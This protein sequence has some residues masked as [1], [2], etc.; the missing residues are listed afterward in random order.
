MA[1]KKQS[2]NSSRSARGKKIL[3]VGLLMALLTGLGI[4]AYAKKPKRPSTPPMPPKEKPKPAPLPAPVTRPVQ[5]FPLRRGMKGGLVRQMQEGLL[6]ISPGSLPRFGA[7]GDFGGE[8]E[9][10]LVTLGFP[11]IVDK[12]IFD[13]ITGTVARSTGGVQGAAK[14][15]MQAMSA[16]NYPAGISVLRS[17]SNPAAFEALDR[18][19]RRLPGSPTALA[20]ARFLVGPNSPLTVTERREVAGELLRIGLVHDQR[21]GTWALPFS[22]SGHPIYDF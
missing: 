5:G 7:D 2:G 3:G 9:S 8:T 10:A 4:A 21:R 14:A 1:N 11:K 6:A 16:K 19:L 22:L 13:R 17:I 20:T 15:L 12:A 18:E